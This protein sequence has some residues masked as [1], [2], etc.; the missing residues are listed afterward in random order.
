MANN[1]Y[2]IT[3]FG[4]WEQVRD[5]ISYSRIPFIIGFVFSIFISILIWMA[6]RFMMGAIGVTGFLVP[7]SVELMIWLSFFWALYTQGII[8]L[9]RIEQTQ[10]GAPVYWGKR[11]N[12]AE[13]TRVGIRNSDGSTKYISVTKPFGY[14][15]HEG[16]F[17]RIKPW[18]MLGCAII[19]GTL[20]N[21][22]FSFRVTDASGAGMQMTVS[23]SFF[24]DLNKTSEFLNI[25]G[26]PGAID[27]IK[28]MIRGSV[29]ETAIQFSTK[30]LLKIPDRLI[31]DSAIRLFGEDVPVPERGINISSNEVYPVDRCSVNIVKYIFEAPVSEIAD[32]LNKAAAEPVQEDR[33]VV[34]AN[35]FTK[36][37]EAT[38]SGLT[39]GGSSSGVDKNQIMSMSHE[40]R[41][42]EDGAKFVVP[43]MNN[44]WDALASY[45]R[46]KIKEK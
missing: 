29:A 43:G 16:R 35:T 30:E 4:I 9:G 17:V 34:D 14:L 22:T 13:T 41:M 42:F 19:D 25:G 26:M 31:R 45:I 37:V 3:K 6:I 46:D 36:V 39:G 2:D 38:L 18:D 12:R 10:W 44:F 27:L 8:S 15:L 24:V 32:E 7:L 33:D 40:R 28:D 5:F 23:F 1:G 21:V 20:Q 11:I